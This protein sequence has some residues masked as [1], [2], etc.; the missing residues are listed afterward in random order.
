MIK[1]TKKYEKKS[2]KVLTNDYKS[3]IMVS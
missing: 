1:K 2:K 3:Y